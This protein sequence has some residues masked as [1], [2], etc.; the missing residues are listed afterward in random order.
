MSEDAEHKRRKETLSGDRPAHRERGAVP[1][2]TGHCAP[3]AAEI[4]VW[5]ECHSRVTPGQ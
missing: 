2:G 5:P 1:P 4:R 3:L